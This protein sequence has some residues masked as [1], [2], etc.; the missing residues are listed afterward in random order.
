MDEDGAEVSRSVLDPERQAQDPG[1]LGPQLPSCQVPPRGRRQANSVRFPDPKAPQLGSKETNDP[2]IP[3]RSHLP[4][5]HPWA[6][7]VRLKPPCSTSAMA[8]V[9]RRCRCGRSEI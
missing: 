4:V 9:G 8:S 1:Y 2:R 6:I 5:G 7:L 3:N